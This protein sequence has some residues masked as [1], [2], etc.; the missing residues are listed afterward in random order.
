VNE[1]S[2]KNEGG[3]ILPERRRWVGRR[4]LVIAEEREDG[5]LL[6][7]AVAMPV[8][9]YTPERKAE[10]LLSTPWRKRSDERSGRW[11]LTEK[12]PHYRPGGSGRSGLPDANILFSAAYK[13]SRLRTL[14]HPSCDPSLVVPRSGKAEVNLQRAKPD[15]AKELEAP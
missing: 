4:A 2:R 12:I 3:V 1:Q 14:D 8:E 9:I 10:F 6:R 13:T 11:A 7:P 15:A 5:I